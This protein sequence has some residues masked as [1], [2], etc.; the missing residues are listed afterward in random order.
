MPEDLSEDDAVRVRR[1]TIWLCIDYE[2]ARSPE[3]GLPEDGATGFLFE[4]ETT[5]D[6]IAALQRALEAFMRPSSWHA[7]RRNAM[8]SEFGWARPAAPAPPR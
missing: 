1:A 2:P 7:L 4:G 8:Q 3:L 5:G 6:V